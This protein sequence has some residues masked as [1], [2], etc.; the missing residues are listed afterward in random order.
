MS[1]TA[2]DTLV[3]SW[4]DA[5]PTVR[6]VAW[7]FDKTVLKLHALGQGI[8]P[9]EV[10]ARWESDVADLDCFVAFVQGA[11]ARGARVAIASFGKLEVVRAYIDCI[12]GT[13]SMAI[14][15]LTPSALGGKDGAQLPKGKPRMLQALMAKSPIIT[16]P[17]AVLFFDDDRNNIHDCHESGF[18]RA[19]HVPRAFTRNALGSGPLPATTAPPG[20]LEQSRDPATSDTDITL[21]GDAPL[22]PP[23]L[24]PSC[25]TPPPAPSPRRHLSA[26]AHVIVAGQ[27]LSLNLE[28]LKGLQVKYGSVKLLEMSETANEQEDAPQAGS[29]SPLLNAL[30]RCLLCCVAKPAARNYARLQEKHGA[31]A[32]YLL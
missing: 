4:L 24:L 1:A 21:A 20:P 10:P 28:R 18:E 22:E 27:R 11:K 14:D 17:S 31:E 32:R 3:S 12:F 15:I 13:S 23:S 26:A 8:Q 2:M 16:D 19:V 7:D 30:R 9:H 29:G 6:L 5:L 25:S